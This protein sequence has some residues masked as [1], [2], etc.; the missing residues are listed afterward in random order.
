MPMMLMLSRSVRR[1]PL[2]WQ[3][4]K[5][6]ERFRPLLAG[7]YAEEAAQWDA[8][9][10]KFDRHE[11]EDWMG[12]E[13]R[14]AALAGT[15]SYEEYDGP[16]PAEED[17]MPTFTDWPPIGIQMYE[18]VSEGTPIS[19]VYEDTPEGRQAMA[20]Y[21]AQPRGHITDGMTVADWLAVINGGLGLKNIHTGKVEI[22]G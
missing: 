15:L 19:P 13:S 17:Y 4:P 11:F 5:D 1:V 2:D 21:L 12:D 6:G 10:A 16:R 8:D 9:K 20:E 7:P 14:D 18:E 22:H 3:H